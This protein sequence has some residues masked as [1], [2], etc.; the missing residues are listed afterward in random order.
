[1][2]GMMYFVKRN[3]LCFFRDKGAVFFSLMSV[4]IVVMLYLLFLRNMLIDSIVSGVE[5]ASKEKLS[6]LVDAWVLSG[7]LGI[8]AVSCSAGSLQSMVDDNLSGKRRDFIVTP[9]KP[10]EMAG[11][12]V[13]ATFFTGVVMSLITLAVA[14]IYLFATGCPMDM[15]SVLLCV[16]L[17]IPSALSG[18]IIL[19]ALVSRIRSN[20]AFTGFFTVVSVLIG[21]LT[22]I[23]MPMGSMN[24]VM[25]TIG[26]L[27]PATHMA[28]LFRQYM[29]SSALKDVF[30]PYDT[31]SFR[32][33]MG[34][35]LSIGGFDFTPAT[36]I[37]YVL[38][39]TAVFFIIAVMLVRKRQ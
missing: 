24:P 11:G 23:Y 32:K 10:Y 26:T 18:S 4:L 14:L 13:I 19:F 34:F 17:L 15:S 38:G 6:N 30:G 28:A 9:M 5:F 22:G 21:F 29:C 33:E 25:Q 1:M 37:I 20:G 31:A 36:S 3:M 2:S 16:L 8:V 35:D 7:I 12:Y 39:V 27:V